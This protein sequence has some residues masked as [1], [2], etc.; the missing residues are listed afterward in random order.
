MKEEPGVEGRPWQLGGHC[1][2]QPWSLLAAA[3]A[4]SRK[5]LVRETEA[6]LPSSRPPAP[7]STRPE[8]KVEPAREAVL[9]S[10]EKRMRGLE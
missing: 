9:L 4:I 6:V 5:L 3:Y 8:V 7:E 1:P 10:G 2:A